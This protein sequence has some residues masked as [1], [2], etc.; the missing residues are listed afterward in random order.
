MITKAFNM[1]HGAKRWNAPAELRASKMGRAEW[2]SGIYG[3]NRI[4]TAQK[5]SK[6]GGKVMLLTLAPSLV[7]EATAIPLSMAIDVA[8]RLVPKGAR[9]GFIDDL[10][11]N[12]QRMKNKM[13]RFHK[14]E[15]HGKATDWMPANV[16]RNLMVNA[17]LCSGKRGLELSQFYAEIGIGYALDKASYG[18]TDVW[19]VIFD[20]KKILSAVPATPEIVEQ[21]GNDLPSPL[22]L[23]KRKKEPNEL[24]M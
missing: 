2:G 19:I 21:Y 13:D 9:E 22:A 6:G 7:L 15:G 23:I 1:W 3:S 10:E 20:P 5:Y 12:C 4:V 24:T 17:N 11:R 14:I 16:L 8:K 18:N